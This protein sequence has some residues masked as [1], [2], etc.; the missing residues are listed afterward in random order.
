MRSV[1]IVGG[2]FAG[3]AAART[4]RRHG[5][6]VDVL[7]LDQKDTSDF[8]PLLPDVIGGRLPASVTRVD[9]ADWAMRRG[10]G[11][12]RA[13]VISVD[14]TAGC[15]RTETESFPYDALI[16]AAGSRTSFH[17]RTDLA[18]RAITLDDTD[19]AVRL[20]TAVRA[21]LGAWLVVGGGYTAIEVA[22]NLRRAAGP[23]G[24]L[25]RLAVRGDTLLR[26]LPGRVRRQVSRALERAD[27]DILYGAELKRW[28]GVRAELS[29]DQTLHNCHVVWCAGVEANHFGG[30]LA[31]GTMGRLKVGA[32]LS[33]APGI[34]GAGDTAEFGTRTG[35]LRMSVQFAVTQGVV[36]ARNALAWL[37]GRPMRRYR[38][39]DL[40]YIVPM[41]AGRGFGSALGIPIAGWPALAVHY[42]MCVLRA[43][44][45]RS[46]R[47]MI[48][49]L[50]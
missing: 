1:I 14:R 28:D 9:L 15:V 41:A 40:G 16:L 31:Y 2:G 35:A 43:Q 6:G 22:S 49:E 17:G 45:L 10:C 12:R 37:N 5:R 25:I 33:A 8:L 50:L 13:R 32:D 44:T 18:G 21:R 4:L 34:F 20:A 26:G 7:L 3:L 27:I 47:E 42:G 30:D 38:P 19:D 48:R 11:F 23:H 24:G 39:L 36:A 29:N 46:K